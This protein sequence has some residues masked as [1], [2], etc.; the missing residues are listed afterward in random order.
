[1]NKSLK[2]TTILLSC[3]IIWGSAFVAQS[4]GMEHLGPFSFQAIRCALAVLGMLPAIVLFDSFKQDGSSFW[5]RWKSPVLWKAGIPCGIALCLATNL[6]Q[7]GLVDSGAGKAAFLTAMYIVMVP[8]IGFFRK[9]PVSAWIWLAVACSVAGLYCLTAADGGTI[10]LADLLL[11]GCAL[12]FAVQISIVD[13]Y[14]GQVDPLRLNLV[15]AFV[16]TLVTTP[17]M[18]LTES[19][20]PRAVWDCAFPLA[21]AG[22]LSMG[23]GYAL[24]I[25]GQ[26]MIPP[27]AASLIMSLESAFAVLFAWI[28]L[29]EALTFWQGIGCVL[30]FA[31]VL[32]AQL[33]VKTKSGS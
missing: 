30:M 12:M 9:K 16:C 17:I 29:K 3:T 31:S 19:P 25:I 26:Q 4:A 5:K 1:M 21:F 24:Q 6:Q 15:Q 7:C 33:P 18:L 20:T 27:A 14:V 22:L 11:L 13:V 10:V 28:F 8:I 23:A 32:I 2:G